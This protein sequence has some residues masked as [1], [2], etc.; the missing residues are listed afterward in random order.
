[1]EGSTI[2][3]VICCLV[4]MDI[5]KQQSSLSTILTWWLSQTQTKQKWWGRSE[6]ELGHHIHGSESRSMD[7]THSCSTTAAPLLS[8]KN[9]E[10]AHQL[11]SHSHVKQRGASP[12]ASS[13]SSF[14]G[15]QVFYFSCGPEHKQPN[16][17]KVVGSV[18][19]SGMFLR[20]ALKACSA[21]Q[22]SVYRAK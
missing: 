19:L 13:N 1:M 5:F 9:Q 2:Q 17:G 6:V 11:E 7:W 12:E 10:W 16:S 3:I 14:E 15:H 18:V 22:V 4:G 21:S 20:H 8:G